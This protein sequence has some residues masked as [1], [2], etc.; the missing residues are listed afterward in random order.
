MEVRRVEKVPVSPYVIEFRA[1]SEVTDATPPRVAPPLARPSPLSPRRP[2]PIF[3]PDFSAL[4]EFFH[5]KNIQPELDRQM[6]KLS[7]KDGE[8][9]HPALPVGIPEFEVTNK[10]TT[11]SKPVPQKARPPEVKRAPALW[12][13]LTRSF[14]A[15]RTIVGHFNAQLSAIKKLSSIFYLL[16]S[17]Q[18][19]RATAVFAVIALI[20][21]LPATGL[22][23][24]SKL[25]QTKETLL[26]K[27]QRALAGFNI[28]FDDPDA[29]K[30]AL[31]SANTTFIDTKNDLERIVGIFGAVLPLIPQV[32]NDYRNGALMLDVGA[33]LTKAGRTITDGFTVMADNSLSLGERLLH[34][35]EALR[36]AFPLIRAAE[37]EIQRIK[38][39]SLPARGREPIATLQILVPSVRAGL[40]QTLAL[41]PALESFLGADTPKRYL[42]I[43]Q[44]PHELRPTGG[45][46]GSFALL[47]LDQGEVTNLEVPTGGPYDLAC[48]LTKHVIAPEPLH[49]IEPHW[50]F[51][52]A[53]WFP[54]FPTSAQKLMWFYG[55]SGGPSVDGVIAINATLIPELLKI[56][57]PIELAIYGRTF[58]AENFLAETQKIVELEYD[59]EENRP[60]AVI[61]DL[62]PI[63]IERLTTL[64]REKLLP[65]VETLASALATKD[66]QLYSATSETQSIF[67][68]HGWSGEVKS[69][70]G[71]FLM[72]VSANIAGGKSSA[73]IETII[74]H[75][76]TVDE[77]GALTDEVRIKKTHT[78]AKSDLFSGVRNVDYLRVYVPEGSSLITA[79][80]FETPPKT[81][82]TRPDADY[83]PDEDLRRVIKPDGTELISGTT[84]TKE[85]GKAVFGNWMQT[86][87]G[88]TTVA[89]LTYRLPKPLASLAPRSGFT[90]LFGL[91][92]RLPYTLLV[93]AQSGT[94]A[95][96][97]HQLIAPQLRKVWG[98][99]A[100][101][102]TLSGDLF[103]AALFER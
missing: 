24:Y 83:K 96:F 12:P 88:E 74:E 92:E 94:S 46:I 20:F 18:L 59:R 52:D 57:G 102:K 35:E 97:S 82:F 30:A 22:Q 39:G 99:D 49:L 60:K 72:V 40:A 54:D 19:L 33:H 103:T 85:H 15:L 62:A 42:V 29:L 81:L 43:F 38:P 69:T 75:R 100:I 2:E 84:I 45:F 17:R 1:A 4:E 10:T 95:R 86:D 65:L 47:D 80:G 78:G 89:T 77:T 36:A 16:S 64:S 14:T 87:P 61:G 7:E 56:T 8:I 70:D 91:P 71:D 26:L 53:N 34:F 63:L 58:T 79:S 55:K 32:G 6:V 41:L 31:G 76:A 51:H 93:Q 37:K 25:E 67:S 66:I 23:A 28:A 3:T 50:Q 27:N 21:T 11:E 73:K 90:T 101:S 68:D 13:L 44:N 98:A 48:C 9:S 5:N